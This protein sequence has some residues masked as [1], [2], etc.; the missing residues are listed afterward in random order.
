MPFYKILQIK[1]PKNCPYLFM[2]YE[3]AKEHGFKLEDYEVVWQGGTPASTHQRA[4]DNLF[5]EFNIRRP[6]DFKGHSMSVS[7]IVQ[8]DG[9]NYYCDPLGWTM[10]DKM[11]TVNLAKALTKNSNC[12]GFIYPVA[13]DL[14]QYQNDNDL[15]LDVEALDGPAYYIKKVFITGRYYAYLLLQG[16]EYVEDGVPLETVKALLHE[17]HKYWIPLTPEEEKLCKEYWDQF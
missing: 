8:I 6:K 17:C 14:Y 11:K 4:L 12:W 15:G 10:I 5:E 1:E 7:D 2:D 3:F 16:N 13:N 9:I